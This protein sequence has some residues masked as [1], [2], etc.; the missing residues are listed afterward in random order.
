MQIENTTK[1]GISKVKDVTIRYSVKTCKDG[2]PA[3][4]LAT[5]SRDSGIIGSANARPNGTL[6]ISINEGNGLDSKTRKAVVD[7]ILDDV[8]EEFPEVE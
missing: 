6:G 3:E 5:I 2:T 7:K 4:V 1:V 8:A